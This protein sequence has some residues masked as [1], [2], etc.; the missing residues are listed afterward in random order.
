MASAILVPCAHGVDGDEGPGEVQAFKEERYR[1]D[2]IRLRIGCL[3]PEHQPLAGSPGRDDMQRV[4]LA[5]A[6]PPR[7]LAVNGDTIGQ[8]FAQTFHP[9][10]E[11]LVEQPAGKGIHHVV[12]RVMRWNTLRKG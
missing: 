8:V 3:L 2:F 12:Q 9:S 1:A 4:A 6:R 7:G 10:C 11:R 5:T